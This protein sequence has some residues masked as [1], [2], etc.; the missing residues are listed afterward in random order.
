MQTGMSLLSDTLIT[1]SN[2]C[3]GTR[4]IIVR[5]QKREEK[6]EVGERGKGLS[7]RIRSDQI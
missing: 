4:L 5:V 7:Q 6:E 1:T 3:D 2:P